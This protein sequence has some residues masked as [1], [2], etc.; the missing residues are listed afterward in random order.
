ML[1][2]FR[3]RTLVLVLLVLVMSAHTGCSILNAM[4]GEEVLDTPDGISTPDIIDVPDG[5]DDADV[6]DASD[7][8]DAT[9]TTDTP[10]IA[11]D[12]EDVLDVMDTSDADDVEVGPDASDVDDAE[13]GPDADVEPICG[14][15]DIEESTK[16]CSPFSLNPCTN[17]ERNC[18]Y[19]DAD[20]EWRCAD[21]RFGDDLPGAVCNPL[22]PDCMKTTMC[23]AWTENNSDPTY[24]F[25]YCLLN[26]APDE[27]NCP[28]DE[29]CVRSS[30]SLIQDFYK[31][32]SK[33]VGF[34]VKSCGDA[35]SQCGEGFEC[36]AIP[37]TGD[38][39]LTCVE[40]SGCLPRG[41]LQ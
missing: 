27:D 22:M 9:D 10:D 14:G 37:A 39:R 29:F 33:D 21:T 32:G 23:A 35:P 28:A 40:K 25:Q 26:K 11:P 17:P 31:L 6:L 8:S 20:S 34:C 3:P 2:I 36:Y 7:A 1:A 41:A 12:I 15:W 5:T 24:C 18:I 16:V 19:A 30:S 38:D 4:F 13:V